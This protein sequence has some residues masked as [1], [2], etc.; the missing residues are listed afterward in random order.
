MGKGSFNPLKNIETGHQLLN[1][2]DP[3]FSTDRSSFL[4]SFT[5]RFLLLLSSSYL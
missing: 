4:R 5:A 2:R 1:L 3:Y